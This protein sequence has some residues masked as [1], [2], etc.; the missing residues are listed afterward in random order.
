MRRVF[1]E[2]HKQ[3]I[4]EGHKGLKH[5]QATK[6]KIS[7]ICKGHKLTDETKRRMSAAKKGSIIT[8]EHRR[9]LSEALKRYNRLNPRGALFDKGQVENGQQGP[10]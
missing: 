5:S 9:K 6:Y 3:R 1:T 7:R 2:Q 8:M 10:V 4:T